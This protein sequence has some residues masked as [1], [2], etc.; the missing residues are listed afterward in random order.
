MYITAKTDIVTLRN[1]LPVAPDSTSKRA[2]LTALPRVMEPTRG[3]TLL[4][5]YRNVG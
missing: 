4:F 5:Q 3:A 2:A 1:P